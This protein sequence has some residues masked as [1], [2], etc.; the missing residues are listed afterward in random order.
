MAR[1]HRL[2]QLPKLSEESKMLTGDTVAKILII[3]AG[4][5]GVL[6][7]FL[8]QPPKNRRRTREEALKLVQNL[9]WRFPKP[10]EKNAP[11]MYNTLHEM[12]WYWTDKQHEHYCRGAYGEFVSKSNENIQCGLRI[13]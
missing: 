11:L 10:L 4:A 7:I 9:P 8:S 5:I 12:A 3:L 13:C 1:N 6:A 2:S